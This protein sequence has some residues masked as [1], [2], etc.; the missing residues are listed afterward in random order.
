MSNFDLGGGGRFEEYA[1]KY[2]REEAIKHCHE[3]YGKKACDAMHKRGTKAA[4]YAK[5]SQKAGAPE[6][7]P[8]FEDWM[9]TH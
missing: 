9:K 2:G 7:F 3:K 5:A 8:S 4:P 6:D 1:R